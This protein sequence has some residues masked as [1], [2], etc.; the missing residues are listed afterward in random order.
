VDASYSF[1][2]G[3]SV[4][5]GGSSLALRGGSKSQGEPRDSKRIDALEREIRELKVMMAASQEPITIVTRSSPIISSHRPHVFICLRLKSSLLVPG[6][7]SGLDKGQSIGR[8][9]AR[10]WN[11]LL[12]ATRRAQR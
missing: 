9:R 8:R 11:G 6:N 5:A 10:Q 12:C 2:M 1:L 4:G 7:V 3:R